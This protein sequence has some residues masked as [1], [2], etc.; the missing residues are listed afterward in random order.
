MTEEIKRK[1]RERAYEIWEYNCENDIPSSELDDWY[2]AEFQVLQE[3][4]NRIIK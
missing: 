3:M 4:E 2:D 1:I